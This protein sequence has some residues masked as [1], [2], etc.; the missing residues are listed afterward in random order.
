MPVDPEIAGVLQLL[1]A[2]DQ[3][4][5]EMTPRQ[6]RDS[7]AALV[8]GGRQPAHVVPVRSVEDVTVTGGAGDLAARV[9][10]PEE[11]GPLPTV[12]LFH[13]GGWVIGDLETHDNMARTI[14]RDSRAVV[15]SVDYR[16]APEAPF[17]AAVEDALAATRWAAAH[18]DELGGSS[19]LA[20]AGDSAGGNLA[21]VVAQELRT[22]VAAQLLVYPATD[23]LGAHP[24]RTENGTGYFL[25]TATMEWFFGHYAGHVTDVDAR[26]SPALAEDLSGLPPAVVVTAEFDP[27]RDEG[28]AYAAALVAAGTRVEARRYDGMV[29]G[30]FDMG[31]A[32]AAARAAVAETCALFGKVLH[33]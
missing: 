33:A 8:V 10:R 24:S 23:M 19:V 4:V 17:P 26:L 16:L 14:A 15:V 7:F 6:A 30:F 29:H 5:H 28:E 3:P 31:P 32:S 20:V 18:L 13:G 11:T 9:Y 22:E 25:E 21:A 27:L 1:A 12:V 2:V